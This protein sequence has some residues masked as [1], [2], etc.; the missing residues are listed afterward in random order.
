MSGYEGLWGYLV[1]VMVG[2][3]PSDLW[4]MLGDEAK[5]AA[6]GSTAGGD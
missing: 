6:G 4:R 5:E 2:F 3:L 1:L